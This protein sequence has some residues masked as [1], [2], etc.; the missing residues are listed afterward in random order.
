MITGSVLDDTFD[1]RD[2]E[3]VKTDDRLLRATLRA[4]KAGPG[5]VDKAV[6]LLNKVLLFRVQWN[7]NGWYYQLVMELQGQTEH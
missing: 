3:W 4:H 7:L 6:D 5:N 2:V 1:S